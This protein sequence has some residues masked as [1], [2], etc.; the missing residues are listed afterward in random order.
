M[1]NKICYLFFSLVL[2]AN[3]ISCVPEF[4]KTVI[5][6]PDE[7]TYVYEGKETVILRA[8]ANVFKEKNIGSNVA[9]DYNNLRVNSDYLYSGDWR[10]KANARVKKISWKECEVTLAVT[11]DKKTISGWETRRLLQKE[12][13][14]NFFSYI[15]LKIYEEM[16]KVE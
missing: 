2:I 8:I 1:V 5:S 7:Y 4:G 6:Q 11:T 12:Q 3:I 14:Y 15:D 9:I 13:Y 10:T 16:S